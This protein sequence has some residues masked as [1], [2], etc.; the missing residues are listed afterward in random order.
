MQYIVLFGGRSFEHEISIVS[1]IALKDIIEA[2]FI[3]ID[4]NRDFYLIP[5]DEMKS[6]TFSKKRFLKFP[7]VELKKGGFY[8]KALLKEKRVDGDVV[9]NLVHGSDGEDGKLAG[10]LEFF[11]MEF[12]GPRVEGSVISYNKLLTKLFAKEVGCEVLEYQVISK[13]HIEPV[14]FSYPVIVKPLR[15]GS[16]IGVSIVKSEDE[17]TYALDVA[18]EFDDEVL[19]EPF[20]EGIKEYNL[21]GCKADSFIFSK[22]EEVQKGEFLDFD[23][24]YRDFSKK[25]VEDAPL[26]EGLKEHIY[27]CFKKI[28]DP[29]FKGSIIRIDFFVHKGELYINEIN[30]IPGSLANYLFEDFPSVLNRLSRYLPKPKDITIDYRYINSISAKK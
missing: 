5:K 10:I 22:L 13:E 4:A 15:L 29:Y 26:S 1:A 11:E 23:K 14:R 12:I 27:D 8:Q 16:S 18:F 21:A 3:Y 25:S 7:K 17:L 24:K 28:Y 20:I 9:I 6:A 2:L 19:I 30:P